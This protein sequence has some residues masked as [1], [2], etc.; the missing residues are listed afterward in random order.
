ML[1]YPSPV[2]TCR[3]M[4]MSYPSPVNRCMMLSYPSP[5]NRCM[6]M[7]YPSPVTRCMMLSYPSPVNRC[8][9]LP[10]VPPTWRR[11]WGVVLVTVIFQY[12]SNILRHISW[13]LRHHIVSNPIRFY[14]NFN[15]R[16]RWNHLIWGL[17]IILFIYIYLYIWCIILALCIAL[18][19]RYFNI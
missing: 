1:S 13:T 9:M 2:T 14:Q 19:L 3:C 5:V 4:M 12:L 11:G 18:R 7:S 6:M 10:S 15:C 8:M 16:V 17:D